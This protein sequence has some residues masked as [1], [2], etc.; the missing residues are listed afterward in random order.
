MCWVDVGECILF[1]SIMV[2]TVG[3]EGSFEESLGSSVSNV[4]VSMVTEDFP[5][6]F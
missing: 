6:R 4:A 1:C 3:V 2:V 5:Y